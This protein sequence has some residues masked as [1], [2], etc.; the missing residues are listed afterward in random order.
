MIGTDELLKVRHWAQGKIDNGQE[1]PW[2]WYRYMQLID[3]L[4]AIIAGKQ[5][6]IG[7][8]E[9]RPGLKVVEPM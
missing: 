5:A 7:G 2:A 1:P 4:D 8:A 6:T 3:A 9:E